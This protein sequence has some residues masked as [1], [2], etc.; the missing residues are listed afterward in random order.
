M[1]FILSGISE[2]LVSIFYIVIAFICS[3]NQRWELVP[4]AFSGGASGKEFDCQWRR[5]KRW[6]QSWG[7]EDPLEEEMATHSSILVWR[8]PWTEK[9][10]R[11]Q[12]MR[13]Q[14]VKC[15]WAHTH[16]HTHTHKSKT[17]S[18]QNSGNSLHSISVC[19]FCWKH[20]EF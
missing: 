5:H 14:R 6:I 8:I 2:V 1:C 15:D 9:P 7:W 17:N 3:H 12:S 16:T 10:G 13:L 20:L 19:R 11:L 4:T 18:S